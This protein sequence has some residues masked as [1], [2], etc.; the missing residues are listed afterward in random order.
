MYFFRVVV[1]STAFL[2]FMPLPGSPLLP[3]S[4]LC[5]ALFDA[6]PFPDKVRFLLFQ[7]SGLLNL[8]PSAFSCFLLKRKCSFASF[9]SPSPSRIFSGTNLEHRLQNLLA[10]NSWFSTKENTF[11]KRRNPPTRS[12]IHTNSQTQQ[13]THKQA[14]WFC[15]LYSNAPSERSALMAYFDVWSPATLNWSI[16]MVPQHV[17]SL[18]PQKNCSLYAGSVWSFI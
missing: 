10:A 18:S 15:I 8:A 1:T 16:P 13:R 11:L 5:Q 9:S 4:K 12:S 6:D 7:E 14:C 3:F 17:A 2:L